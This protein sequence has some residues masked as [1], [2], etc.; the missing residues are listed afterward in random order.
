MSEHKGKKIA[1]SRMPPV[2][3]FSV[4]EVKY[5]KFVLFFPIYIYIDN[6]KITVIKPEISVE[7]EHFCARYCA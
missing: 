4:I 7:A 6:F 1:L 2:G 5:I 3:A